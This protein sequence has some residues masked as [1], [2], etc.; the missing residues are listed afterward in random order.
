VLVSVSDSGP[1]IPGSEQPHVF[2]PFFRGQQAR[3]GQIRGS[4][5]GL[6]LVQRIAEA[7]GGRV[8]L[9]SSPRTG[10]RFTIELPAAPAK[11]APD[12]AE[13]T[14]AEAHPSR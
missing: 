4:G 3:D 7:H 12:S 6:N 8:T 5:L 2:E 11:T 9:D 13:V 10:S 14:R 1:G